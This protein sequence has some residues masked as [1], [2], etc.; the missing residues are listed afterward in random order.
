MEFLA[1][2][3]GRRIGRKIFHCQVMHRHKGQ[4]GVIKTGCTFRTRRSMAPIR[5]PGRDGPIIA[6]DQRSAVLGN[7]QNILSLF[8]FCPEAFGAK[9]EKG[10]RL[11]SIS[12]IPML[13]KMLGRPKF[14][15][16]PPPGYPHP[17]LIT[18]VPARTQSRSF[19][20]RDCSSSAAS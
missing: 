15:R 18:P 17:L 20:L 3:N 16:A 10:T 14:W 1:N 8:L 13:A 5:S 12:F 11:V 6:Q 2:A 4:A 19:V 7:R 9:Q